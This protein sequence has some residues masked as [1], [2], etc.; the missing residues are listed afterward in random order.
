MTPIDEIKK[1]VEM[2][3]KIPPARECRKASYGCLQ[4]MQAVDDDDQHEMDMK[5]ANEN[6]KKLKE[7]KGKEDTPCPK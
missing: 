4:L 7:S 1:A 5:H 3:N 2:L 6:L